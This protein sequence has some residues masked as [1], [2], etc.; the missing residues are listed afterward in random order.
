MKENKIYKISNMLKKN[1]S[2]EN[3]K[4]NWGNYREDLAPP[5]WIKRYNLFLGG[6]TNSVNE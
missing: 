1:L 5:Q 6:K 4:L 3:V 2:E